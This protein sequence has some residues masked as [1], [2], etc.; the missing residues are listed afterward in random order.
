[1]GPTRFKRRLAGSP[2]FS[3]RLFWIRHLIFE[4][5]ETFVFGAFMLFLAIYT[6][7]HMIE[8]GMHLL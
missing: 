4:T 1:M 3:R 6:I 7:V 5:C 8:F 2:N